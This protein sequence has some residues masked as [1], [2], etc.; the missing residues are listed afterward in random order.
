MR[1]WHTSRN[2]K[3]R[4]KRRHTQNVCRGRQVVRGPRETPRLGDGLAEEKLSEGKTRRNRVWLF[5]Y[6]PPS[7]VD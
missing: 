6:A 2:G 7:W 1:G 3:E 5:S 4:K